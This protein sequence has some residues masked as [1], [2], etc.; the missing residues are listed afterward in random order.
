MQPSNV[1]FYNPETIADLQPPHVSNQQLPPYFE[2]PE[3]SVDLQAPTE[4]S[5]NPNNDPNLYYDNVPVLIDIE[6][7]TNLHP[8]KFSKGEEKKYSN[9]LKKEVILKPITED[10]LSQLQ[11]TVNKMAKLENQKQIKRE[12][13]PNKSRKIKKSVRNAS[14]EPE[15]AHSQFNDNT[16]ED[17]SASMIHS[18]GVRASPGERYQFHMHGHK[19]PN[20]YKWGFDTGKG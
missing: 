16:L 4:G 9:E 1:P 19:G 6:N 7:P 15:T 17:I 11:K 2:Y 18:L 8:K 3:P 10:E 13:V 14:R 20:S 12:K 5:W